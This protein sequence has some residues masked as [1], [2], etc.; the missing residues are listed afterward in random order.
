ME[1]RPSYVL[2]HP[3]TSPVSISHLLSS[4]SAPEGLESRVAS[5]HL[6]ELESQLAP[7]EKFMALCS[8]HHADLIKSI[9]AHK[10]ILS[11]IRRLPN[12]LLAEIFMLLVRDAFHDLNSDSG[13]ISEYP[14]VLARVCRHW[15][16][17]ALGTRTLWSW[18]FLDLDV[19]GDEQEAV[20]M[21]QLFHERSGNSPLTVNIVDQ[22]GTDTSDVFN[23][24]LAHAERWQNFSLTLTGG[25]LLA[26]ALDGIRGRLDPLTTLQIH[27]GM[28]MDETRFALIDSF[29][30]AP[31][32]TAVHL[33]VYDS[34]GRGNFCFP[35]PL[36]WSQLT[37]LSLPLASN[38]EALSILPQLS[39]IVELQ[40]VFDGRTDVVP[41]QN[42]TLSCLRSLEIKERA[43]D[44]PPSSFLLNCLTC[45]ILKHLLTERAN[46]VGAALRFISRSGCSK[47]LNSFHILLHP[48]SVDDTLSLVRAMPRL[49]V[50]GVGDFDDGVADSEIVQALHSHWLSVRDNS[51]TAKLSVQFMNGQGSGSKDGDF[52]ALSKD[53][54]FID[55]DEFQELDSIIDAKYFDYMNVWYLNQ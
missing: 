21:T 54:F 48:I 7:L 22:S 24:V 47:T 8:S 51:E 30:T 18:V 13:Q 2:P 35:I 34:N 44:D 28:S 25:S 1:A 16:V 33:W 53:G 26:L 4:N 14:W 37:C 19:I 12:E 43:W 36:P 27:A 38:E 17:V 9:K 39:C 55:I 11:P 50:L 46:P 15:N 29:T 49:L 32:L 31:N 45:P 23:V 20:A 5:A 41:S 10:S 3:I 52:G 6:A 40:M 42:I